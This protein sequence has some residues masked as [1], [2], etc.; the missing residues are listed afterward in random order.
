MNGQ[1]LG[2]ISFKS[3]FWIQLA[4]LL[5]DGDCLM[6]CLVHN[7]PA[8]FAVVELP[9]IW[10]GSLDGN[11][12]DRSEVGRRARRVCHV[13]DHGRCHDDADIRP[14]IE[15]LRA[16]GFS[17]SRIANRIF[18]SAGGIRDRMAFVF[19][20][21]DNRPVRNAFAAFGFLRR[22]NFGTARYGR[23]IVVG[24]A[25]PVHSVEKEMPD[26]LPASADAI[27]VGLAR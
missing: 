23:T 6:A 3:A 2:T 12:P 15:N 16:L 26:A 11:L 8:S 4:C 27:H 21:R 13:V 18:S 14:G 9:R 1:N 22:Y 17:R 20:R 19:D 7:Q 10:I 24:R 5:P 25:V